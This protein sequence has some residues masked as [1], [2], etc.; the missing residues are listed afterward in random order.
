LIEDVGE[1]IDVAGGLELL[2]RFSACG[3]SQRYDESRSQT[4]YRAQ[5][6]RKIVQDENRQ[7][8]IVGVAA[9]GIVI[10]ILRYATRGAPDAH[11]P[12][13]WSPGRLVRGLHAWHRMK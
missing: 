1:I 7:A 5:G 12:L 4:K 13:Q 6:H 10:E 2:D 8:V 11:W 3:D 9:R